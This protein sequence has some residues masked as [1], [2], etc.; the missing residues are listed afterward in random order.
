MRNYDKECAD[1]LYALYESFKESGFDSQQAFELVSSYVRQSFFD[2]TIREL[3]RDKR[4]TDLSNSREYM[5][6]RTAEGAK[7]DG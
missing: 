6:N 4:T 3:V 7:E 1:R 2:N 5:R